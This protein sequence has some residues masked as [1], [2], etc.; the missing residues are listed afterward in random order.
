MLCRSLLVACSFLLLAGSVSGGNLSPLPDEA[1]NVAAGK[2]RDKEYR[3]AREAALR[4]PEGGKR[5]F[6][7]GIDAY[8]LGL[9][10]EA[11]SYLGRAADSFPLLA[12]YALYHQAQAL[13]NLKRP[14]DATVPLQRL[15]K[16]YP[17]TPLLRAAELLRADL[18]NDGGD[19]AGAGKAYQ[20]FIG[21]YPAGADA[22]NALYSAALCREKLGETTAAVAALRSIRLKYPAADV[23]AKAEADL[24][25]LAALGFSVAPYTADELYAMGVTLYDLGKYDR[26]VTTLTSIPPQP[27]TTPFAWRL[28]LKTGQALLKARR[29][30]EAEETF[31]DLIALSPKREIAVEA[32]YLMAKAMGKRGKDDEAVA[33]YLVVTDKNPS[34]DLADDALLGAASVRKFQRRR[35]EQLTLLKRLLSEYPESNLRR[36][37]RWEMAWASY[38][39]G[40]LSTAATTFRQLTTDAGMREKALYWYGRSLLAAGEAA[41][42]QASFAML[43]D[44]YPAGFYAQTYRKETKTPELP[45]LAAPADLT[46]TLPLPV[47]YDRIKALVAMGFYDEA[48]KELAAVK[49]KGAGQQKNLLGLARLYLEMGDYHGA[50]ALF[51][52]ERP[53]RLDRETLTLWEISY[54]L[55]FRDTVGRAARDNGLPQWLIYSVISAESSFLPTALSPVGAMGLMQIMPATADAIK[56]KRGATQKPANLNDPEVNIAL[57][58]RHLRNLLNLYHGDVM[59]AVAAY[60]AGS[61]N[62]SRWKKTA[63]N[64]RDDEFIEGIPFGETRD[65]VKKVLAGAGVYERLYTSPPASGQTP[66]AGAENGTAPATPAEAPPLAGSDAAGGN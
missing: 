21:K 53:R 3:E 48:R 27:G 17:E 9:W 47:G 19:F 2:N 45:P 56:G 66:T 32:R 44:E 13:R 11:A 14:A 18:L 26:A 8:K 65:Y 5:D 49:G 6:L 34:S 52:Q 38:L 58:A 62:V 41:T 33:A 28:S 30:K 37:A 39:A 25:R 46:A 63:G 4:A 22:L 7:V 61:G 60:N 40:D 36:E 15:L 64:L 24:Q 31:R 29:Y 50:Q 54:P 57:G 35:D 12:D 16:S 55:A 1:L 59:A 42:A 51:R 10:E 23:A 43:L 20:D